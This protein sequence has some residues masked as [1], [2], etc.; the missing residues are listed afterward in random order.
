LQIPL[1]PL[2]ERGRCG[3]TTNFILTRIRIYTAVPLED[4]LGEG[5]LQRLKGVR[6]AGAMMRIVEPAMESAKVFTVW[7]PEMTTSWSAVARLWLCLWTGV[8]SGLSG[9]RDVR[10]KPPS[11]SGYCRAH[12][13]DDRPTPRSSS[14]R[15]RAAETAVTLRKVL[16]SLRKILPLRVGVLS[17]KS[18]RWDIL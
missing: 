13:R 15:G 17:I 5:R 4:W 3:E 11:T 12:S 7:M 18:M 9:T 10:A 2:S 8:A 14:P 6:A 16:S 1:R